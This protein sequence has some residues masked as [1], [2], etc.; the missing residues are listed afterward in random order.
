MRKPH[1]KRKF[2]LGITASFELLLIL[3]L[4]IGI[5]LISGQYDWFEK[6]ITFAHQ[7]EEWEIDEILVI[8]F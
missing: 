7:Y 4:A 5:Y 6:L 8:T 1:I 2:I 3:C